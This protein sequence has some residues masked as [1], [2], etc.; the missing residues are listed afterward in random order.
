MAGKTKAMS[1]IKQLLQMYQKDCKIKEIAR[2]LGMSKNTVKAYL[3]KYR[4]LCYGVEYLLSLDDPVLESK[5]HSGNPAYKENQRYEFIKS[6]VGYY[7][8]EL[9]RVGVT[10]RLL[11]EEYKQTYPDGYSYSQFCYHLDQLFNTRNPSMVLNHNPGEKLFVDFAGKKMSYADIETGEVIECPVFVACLPYSDYG[12]AMAVKSQGIEDFIY[13]LQCCIEELG[14]VP[15]VLIPDNLK[16]AVI[17]A[18]KYEPTINRVLEDFC[19][20]YGMTVI[21][22]RVKKPQ[23]KALVED[24]VKLIYNRVYAKLRDITFFDLYSLNSA[25]KEKV[26]DHNQTRMQRNPYCREEKFLSDEKQTLST[27]PDEPFE[28]KYYKEYKVDTNNHIRLTEDNH[29]YSVPLSM[30]RT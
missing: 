24:Q 21:P 16:A 30:D 23:D 17:K 29:Y 20:H 26:R 10:R 12:F 22:A 19:N 11:W 14:G 8:K 4:S 18:N 2:S 27:L 15:Q 7:K 3:D 6:K 25:I 5:F 13:A 1:Q 9:K 28:V